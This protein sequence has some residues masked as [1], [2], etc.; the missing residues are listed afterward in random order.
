MWKNS[1]GVSEYV[2]PEFHIVDEA[3]MLSTSHMKDMF[4]NIG[5]V[6][7]IKMFGDGDQLP[8]IMAGAPFPALMAALPGLTVTLRRNFRT[9]FAPTLMNYM[10]AIHE[11][12]F[13][14]E[15]TRIFDDL[16]SE[17]RVFGTPG[18]GSSFHVRDVEYTR[19]DSKLVF[20]AKI[21]EVLAKV[22]PDRTRYGDIMCV[23]P[24]NYMAEFVS[25]LMDLIYIAKSPHPL[26]DAV[27]ISNNDRAPPTLYVGSWVV[28]VKTDEHNKQ[29]AQGRVARLTHIVDHERNK[30]FD[31]SVPLPPYIFSKKSTAERMP[32]RWQRTLV[33]D[34]RTVATFNSDAAVTALIRPSACRTIHRAQGCQSPI[35][36]CLFPTGRMSNIAVWYTGVSR[37]QRQCVTFATDETILTMMTT[38]PEKCHTALPAFLASETSTVVNLPEMQRLAVAT[39][40]A[41]QTVVDLTDEALDDDDDDDAPVDM[42]KFDAAMANIL[43]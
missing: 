20:G 18:A 11:R 29:L 19:E 10:T 40:E 12:N 28:V 1:E 21:L 26:N 2:E 41:A 27:T 39:D 36:F 37:A 16:A 33:L 13:A 23:T 9:S 14:S 15:D 3:G 31:L 25:V 43:A 30:T 4:L 5:A 34:G 24:Y 7:Q 6:K 35:V 17:L 38:E 42:E 32:Y 22:D 8:P